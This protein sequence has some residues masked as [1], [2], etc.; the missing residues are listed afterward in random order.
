MFWL[1]GQLHI[2]ILRYLCLKIVIK[3]TAGCCKNGVLV[4]CVIFGI[5]ITIRIA[6]VVQRLLWAVVARTKST[7]HAYGFFACGAIAN[8]LIVRNFA[9]CALKGRKGKLKCQ[10]IIC[11]DSVKCLK[12]QRDRK[13]DKACTLGYLVFCKVNGIIKSL[14]AAIKQK[15]R[16]C[17]GVLKGV[18]PLLRDGP[19]FCVVCKIIT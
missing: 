16:G 18:R 19:K 17:I 1:Q 3:K 4:V 13:F 5:V 12:G 11:G 2:M 14:F 9:R 6:Q 15:E 8:Y 7:R 10:R